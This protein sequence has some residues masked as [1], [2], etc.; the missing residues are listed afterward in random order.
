MPPPFWAYSRRAVQVDVPCFSQPVQGEVW[1]L[2]LEKAFAKV[3]GRPG[4]KQTTGS[5]LAQG[6]FQ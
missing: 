1:P 6:W 4:R 5:G 3:A 2:L